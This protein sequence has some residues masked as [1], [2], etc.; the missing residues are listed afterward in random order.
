[1]REIY[2][3]RSAKLYTPLKCYRLIIL[4]KSVYYLAGISP[5]NAQKTLRRYKDIIKMF[6]TNFYTFFQQPRRYL[7]EWWSFAP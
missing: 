6:L 3:L 2:A 7:R 5:R 4:C 1:M